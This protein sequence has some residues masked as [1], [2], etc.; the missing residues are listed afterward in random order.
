MKKPYIKFTLTQL[1]F[2]F[3][4]KETVEK[5]NSISKILLCIIAIM[6]N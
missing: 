3:I 6:E 5:M 4:V 2:I 1:S